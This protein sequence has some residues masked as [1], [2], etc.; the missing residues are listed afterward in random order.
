MFDSYIYL[1]NPAWLFLANVVS[2]MD[3][4]TA[5]RCVALGW[6]SYEAFV[7]VKVCKLYLQNHTHQMTTHAMRLLSVG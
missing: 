5:M 7:F 1:Q 2:H 6:L 4:N 3:D